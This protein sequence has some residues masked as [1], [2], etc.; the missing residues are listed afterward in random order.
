MTQI[1]TAEFDS[2]T[3]VRPEVEDPAGGFCQPVTS[4]EYSADSL[5]GFRNEG[6]EHPAPEVALGKRYRIR[7]GNPLPHL[8]SPLAR[9]YMVEDSEI[10][11]D[12]LF[13]LVCKAKL[14]I[15]IPVLDALCKLDAPG[16]IAIVEWGA[17]GWPDGLL[18]RIAVICRKPGGRR[19]VLSPLAEAT[20]MTPKDIVRKVVRPV[21]TALLNLD[22]HGIAHRAVRPDNLFFADSSNNRVLLGECVTSAPGAD[23][24]AVYET[25]ENGMAHP[26]GRGP[27]TAA[28][29][30]YALGV[31]I[32]HLFNGAPPLAEV[33]APEIVHRKLN[34][35]SYGALVGEQRLPPE[36]AEALRGLLEDNPLE[37]WGYDELKSWM[38]G[39]HPK[40][41][42][43]RASSRKSWPFEFAGV[44]YTDR[45]VLAHAFCLDW[46]AAARTIRERM[47][48]NWLKRDNRYREDAAEADRL[49]EASLDKG[50]NKD[51]ADG[52]LVAKV[53]ILLDPRAPIRYM[54]LAV[55]VEGIG[56]VLAAAR[57]DSAVVR[58]IADMLS[59][60]LPLYWIAR[61]EAGK[62]ALKRLAKEFRKVAGYLK[63]TGPGFGLERGLYE[64][65]PRYPCL[66]PMLENSFVIDEGD[67]LS[68]LETA[69]ARK[70][71]SSAP[72]DRHLAAFLAARCKAI[73]DSQLAALAKPHP[74]E[75]RALAALGL[76]ALVQRRQGPPSLPALTAWIVA[77]A[78]PVIESV[79]SRSLRRWLARR[80][81][82]L[83][84][85]GDLSAAFH[86]LNDQELLRR[87]ETGF[88]AASREYAQLEA[89]IAV[90]ESDEQK[91][92]E[93]AWNAGRKVVA[94]LSA[95]IAASAWILLGTLRFW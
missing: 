25:I 5:A 68:A 17:I 55:N 90:I 10:P 53:C 2:D 56:T 39:G 60:D 72:M 45:R 19:L 82:G 89:G 23:Q 49:I 40:V 81:D 48:V 37:R 20:P 66:S 44:K 3:V 58:G 36:I 67:L 84:A 86:T 26:S 74:A 28:D 85:L 59:R 41:R 8:D 43:V 95:G 1:A 63:R 91:S 22:R 34:L 6:S 92:N 57:D 69:A 7:T 61:Q 62:T 50:R 54:D 87:D 38:E 46:R 47:I 9:A 4:G 52:V 73:S 35:G 42:H 83:I 30:L 65:N 93:V 64:L 18:R 33:P 13:A 79:H 71:R 88:A 76:L 11:G 21:F 94:L 51:V 80:I 70:D 32:L 27:G 75:R 77:A 31:L 29:D 12:H 15:R 16:R 24:P 14:P 78:R